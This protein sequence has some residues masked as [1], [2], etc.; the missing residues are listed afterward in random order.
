EEQEIVFQARSQIVEVI[1]FLRLLFL[2]HGEIVRAEAAEHIR[3]AGLEANHLRILAGYEEKR[4][5]V[6]IWQLVSGAIC[7]PIIWI[8]FKHHALPGHV[9]LQSKWAET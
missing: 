4:D 9:F 2:Q 7:F 5:F 3:V 6:E 8:A 1:A